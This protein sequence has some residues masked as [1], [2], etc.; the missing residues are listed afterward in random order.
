MF[1][2]KC[3]TCNPR[4]HKSFWHLSPLDDF[5]INVVANVFMKDRR[6][7]KHI[8]NP[9]KH[10]RWSFFQKSLMTQ[11]FLQKTLACPTRF[12]IRLCL[13][14]R[15]FLH[16]FRERNLAEKT[17]GEL[18]NEF[19]QIFDETL[20]NKLLH[21]PKTNLFITSLNIDQNSRISS[22]SEEEERWKSN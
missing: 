16:T 14:L 9:L 19:L 13:L 3:L 2:K 22:V 5:T 21:L 12:W 11:L 4:E 20:P 6:S 18:R 7:Q 8:Q 10:L 1:S 15:K 17:L